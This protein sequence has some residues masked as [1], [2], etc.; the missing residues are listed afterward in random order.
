MKYFINGRFTSRKV[1]GQERFAIEV[2]KSLDKIVEN[3]GNQWELIVPEYADNIP[4]LQNIKIVKK[5]KVKGH[6]WEQ[7]SFAFYSLKNKGFTINMCMKIPFIS[8]GVVVIH[9]MAYK[10]PYSV[11]KGKPTLRRR[12]SRIW[13]RVH[14]RI[15]VWRCPVIFTVSAYSKKQI[16]DFYNIPESKVVVLGNGW[17]HFESVVPDYNILNKHK[18]LKEGKFF[19]SLGSLAANKNIEWILK[20]AKKYPQYTFAIAGNMDF[21]RFGV[22]YNEESLK[23]VILLGY[24][25]DGE[26]KAL[27]S[28]C[29]AFLFPSYFEGFGIPPLEAMSVGSEVISANTT[30]LPEIYENTV[31]YIDPDDTDVDLD[32]LLSEPVG[33]KQKILVKYQWNKIAQKM[34]DAIIKER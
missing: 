8:P 16:V 23:N 30:C 18:Q 19:F 14:H 5:G 3:D 4:D 7:T 20:V 21:A 26:V 22:K 10:L 25:S 13:H 1:T 2:V 31:H 34:Y 12:L 17:Q 11:I 32:K 15:S 27:M 6:F 28:K 29:R 24:I 33:D 9:D